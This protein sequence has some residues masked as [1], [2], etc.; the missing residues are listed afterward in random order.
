MTSYLWY[1]TGSKD[2]RI[3][4]CVCVSVCVK[5][6]CIHYLQRWTLHQRP[7]HSTL[8]GNSV[9]W[10]Y[11]TTA[12]Y[13]HPSVFHLLRHHGNCTTKREDRPTDC[14]LS[15]AAPSSVP[16]HFPPLLSTWICT[17]K[18]CYGG[19]L[20]FDVA[21]LWLISRFWEDLRLTA[22]IRRQTFYRY[23]NVYW[24]SHINQVVLW[25]NLLQV[26]CYVTV[27]TLYLLPVNSMLLMWFKLHALRCCLLTTVEWFREL[28]RYYKYI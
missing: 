21:K 11:N 24:M 25:I 26:P 27:A 15:S 3:S 7:P 10:S 16:W 23:Y 8:N 20:L 9:P 5:A 22:I 12:D 13:L 18:C 19:G 14:S 28:L 1:E 6:K 17:V 4:V 2:R